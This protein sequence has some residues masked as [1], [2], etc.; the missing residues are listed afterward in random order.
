MIDMSCTLGALRC[1]GTTRADFGGNIKW[2]IAEF[3]SKSY[4]GQRVKF[5]HKKPPGLLHPLF[6]PQWK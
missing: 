6:I 5:E 3:V 1:A 2:E 4:T